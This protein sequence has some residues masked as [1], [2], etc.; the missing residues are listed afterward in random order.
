MSPSLPGVRDFQDPTALSGPLNGSSKRDSSGSKHAPIVARD[1][2]DT[3]YKG[4]IHRKFVIK[5]LV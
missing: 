1:S 4:E 3:C 2:T 5:E